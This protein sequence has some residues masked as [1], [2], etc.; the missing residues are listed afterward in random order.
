M[1]YVTVANEKKRKKK[2]EKREDSYAFKRSCMHRLLERIHVASS[3]L[4]VRGTLDPKR[5]NVTDFRV[6]LKHKTHLVI[7]LPTLLTLL[8]IAVPLPSLITLLALINLHLPLVLH[9]STDLA[10]ARIITH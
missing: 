4:I 2:K 9:R 1:L 3:W 7:L 5:M 10:G 6:I 8:A